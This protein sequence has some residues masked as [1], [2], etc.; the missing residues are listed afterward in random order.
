MLNGIMKAAAFI[1]IAVIAD[2]L[3]TD[4]VYTDATLSILRQMEHSF[5]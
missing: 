4:G 1:G 5:R 3:F 2:R